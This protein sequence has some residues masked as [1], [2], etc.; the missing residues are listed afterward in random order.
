MISG[1]IGIGV[2][3]ALNYV[4]NTVVTWEKGR[5]PA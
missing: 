2:A 5:S 4:L 1:A 3:A